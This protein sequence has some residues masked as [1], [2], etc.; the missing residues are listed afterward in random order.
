MKQR[1]SKEE[2]KFFEISNFCINTDTFDGHFCSLLYFYS[3]L[4]I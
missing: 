1:K 3:N 2:D 4:I